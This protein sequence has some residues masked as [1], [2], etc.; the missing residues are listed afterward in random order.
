VVRPSAQCD[1]AANPRF[2]GDRASV[3]SSFE[4]FGRL[5][6]GNPDALDDQLLTKAGRVSDITRSP[7]NDED[8]ED[9]RN[10]QG[11]ASEICPI[12]GVLWNLETDFAVLNRK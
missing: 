8:N 5:P 12:E 2:E 3:S 1:S 10:D 6:A 9:N 7:G 4:R 11:L